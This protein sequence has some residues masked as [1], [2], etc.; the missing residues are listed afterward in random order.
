[1]RAMSGLVM[2]LAICDV[3]CGT[4]H[5]ETIAG[6]AL[7]EE[8]ASPITSVDEMTPLGFSAAHILGFAR[9][10]FSTSL[11][12][13]SPA[14]LTL[15]P[16]SGRSQLS[17]QVAY[18]G[19]AIEFVRSRPMGENSIDCFD[20]LRIGVGIRLRTDGGALD[21]YAEESLKAVTP[22]Y[23][24]VSQAL[25]PSMLGGTLEIVPANG[26]VTQLSA[27]IAMSP[28]GTTGQIFS[29]IETTSSASV[30]ARAV[31][32]ATWPASPACQ[33]QRGDAPGLPLPVDVPFGKFTGLEAL[34]RI[35]V[36]RDRMLTWRDETTAGVTLTASNN[37][38]GCV[39]FLG[40]SAAQ[41]LPQVTFPVTISIV[42]DDA[43]LTGQYSGELGA[44][45]AAD[46]SLAAVA[47]RSDLRFGVDQS[48]MTGFAGLG[49]VS[50]YDSLALSILSQVTGG[51]LSGE[52]VLN[53][54]KA[55]PCVGQSQGE[56]GASTT[57]CE[58]TKFTVIERGS[59]RF[60]ATP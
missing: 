31:S 60:D 40:Q 37:G 59:W 16:E 35:N 4:S 39:H 10:E 33:T 27:E 28:L 58:G 8:T 42:T 26:Q 20:H 14:D 46:G 49:N 12:W 7:C 22:F 53:G 3:G 54:L 41:L 15:G 17:F 1:M 5:N 19:G 23:A 43:R 25:D 51:T 34:S 24:S 11:L 32:Y 47:S 2:C 21:E 44:R 29:I 56:P 55:A 48:G 57:A 52:V 13:T 36:V 38:D 45:P 18:N 6:G 50:Q 30:G 9:G